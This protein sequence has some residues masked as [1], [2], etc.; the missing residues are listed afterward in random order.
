M[1]PR[2][3]GMNTSSPARP[4]RL[5][6]QVLLLVL[7]LVVGAMALR[8]ALPGQPFAPPL[9]NLSLQRELLVLHAVAGGLALMLGPWQFSIR[10]RQRRPRLHRVLG[11][12]YAA[13]LLLGGLAALPL[14]MQSDGGPIAQ[15]GFGLLGGLWLAS[16][17]IA[18]IHIRA[19]RID[20]HRRWM[21]RSFVLTAGGITLRL[22]I[23]AGNLLGVPLEA[24]YTAL[25]WTSWLPQA[26]LLEW[27][28]RRAP[29]VARPQQDWPDTQLDA[30]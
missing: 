4:L 30:R 15:L 24:Y 27:W 5:A 17:G 18:L 21:L 23:V 25:A 3:R 8:Y 28:L 16:T 7:A 14:A 13:C 19:R 6:A 12:V 22:Q 29:R 2:L 10:L 11:W 9:P 26:L 1:P 20:Q